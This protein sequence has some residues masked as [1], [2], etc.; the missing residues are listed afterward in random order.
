M[1]ACASQDLE[2]RR[3]SSGNMGPVIADKECV[4]H[5]SETQE[6]EK[7]RGGMDRGGTGLRGRE[8]YVEHSSNNKTSLRKE[9]C[10]VRES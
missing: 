5:E 1:P 8:M 10:I 4:R 9:R 6:V 2:R 3:E 7:R